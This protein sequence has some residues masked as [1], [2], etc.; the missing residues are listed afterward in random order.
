MYKIYKTLCCFNIEKLYMYKHK[1]TDR[2]R[3]KERDRD[4]M[5]IDQPHTTN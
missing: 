3:D 1:E 4:Q 5:S 2:E